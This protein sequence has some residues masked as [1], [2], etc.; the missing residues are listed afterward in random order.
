MR[1]TG[2]S[3]R[4]RSLATPKD[5]AIRPTSDKV[6]KALFDILGD[7]IRGTLFLDCYAG[8]GAVGLE[9]LSRGARAAVF[10]EEDR[11]AL[12]LIRKNAETLGLEIELL[13]G[14]FIKIAH[15]LKKENRRFD[16]IFIDPPYQ[17]GQ[18]IQTIE[19]ISDA[20]LLQSEGT[21]IVEHDKRL[22]LPSIAGEFSLNNHRRYGETE[23]SFFTYTR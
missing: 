17:K 20:G 3:H 12:A 13:P 2:G 22:E 11:K 6:R 19:K 18:Q 9:A 16:V 15:R 4:N 23:L 7:R 8:T 5:R 21:V 14:D 1:I 10:I